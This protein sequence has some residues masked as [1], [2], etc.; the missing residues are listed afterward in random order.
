A[1]RMPAFYRNCVRAFADSPYEVL[2]SVGGDTNIKALGELPAH[3]TVRPF[4]DQITVLKRADAFL[5]HCGMNSVS[6]ALYHGVPLVL[7]P[8]TAEQHRVASR[9][10]ELGAG[11]LLADTAPEIIR[12]AIDR[13]LADQTFAER[14]AEIAEGFHASGGAAAAAAFI[15]EKCNKKERIG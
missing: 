7:F 6:E 15:Q 14:A 3:I 4:V 10:A 11:I 12:A 8:Q 9:T 5:T 1:N 2:L 13:L